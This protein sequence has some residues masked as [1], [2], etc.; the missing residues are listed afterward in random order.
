MQENRGLPVEAQVVDHDSWHLDGERKDVAWYALRV[1]W[2]NGEYTEK[3]QRFSH[4]YNALLKVH[5]LNE[6]RGWVDKLPMLPLSASIRPAAESTRESRA[7]ELNIQLDIMLRDSR[8]RS[9]PPLLELLSPDT[10]ARSSHLGRAPSPATGTSLA[11]PAGMGRTAVTPAAGTQDGA[12]LRQSGHGAASQVHGAS[13]GADAPDQSDQEASTAALQGPGDPTF[14]EVQG[15]DAP[16][17][18][19]PYPHRSGVSVAVMRSDKAAKVSAIVDRCKA[20]V[21]ELK[22]ELS[23]RDVTIRELREELARLRGAS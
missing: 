21:L 19:R 11:T 1:R 18:P 4:I 13:A 8:L 20:T 12:P 3:W 9:L 17:I 15:L 6:K 14:C 2:S 5:Q 22:A 16:R 7:K 10:G 23:E